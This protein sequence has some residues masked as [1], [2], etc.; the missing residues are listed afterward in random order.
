M[1]TL[2]VILLLTLLA[3]CSHTAGDT[4]ETNLSRPTALAIL[5]QN[6]DKLGREPDNCGL[7]LSFSGNVQYPVGTVP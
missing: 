2:S 6:A 5:R 1:K 4:N 3:G 7:E